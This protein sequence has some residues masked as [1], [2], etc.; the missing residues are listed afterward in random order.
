MAEPGGAID[1]AGRES[2]MLIGHYPIAFA[3]EALRKSPSRAAGFVA[4]QWVD[5]GFFSLAFVGVE[6]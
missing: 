2:V 3:A 4:A 1:R 6:K 5:M